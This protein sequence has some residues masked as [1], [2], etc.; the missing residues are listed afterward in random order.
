LAAMALITDGGDEDELVDDAGALVLDG[1]RGAVYLAAEQRIVVRDSGGEDL[2]RITRAQVVGALGAALYDQHVGLTRVSRMDGAAE[3]SGPRSVAAGVSAAFE[4]RYVDGLPARLQDA[5]ADASDRG[6]GDDPV[7]LVR[8]LAMLSDDLGTGLVEMALADG[9]LEED[10]SEWAVVDSLVASPPRTEF[11]L[12]QPWAT[13]DGFERVVVPAP[14]VDEGVEV[15]AEGR[16]GAATLYWTMALRV[17]AR[18]ALAVSLL[19]AGDAHVL[20]R[21]D[22]G[23]RCLAMSV[24]GPD[25]DSS[26]R[27]E[28]VLERWVE[29][30]PSDADAEIERDGRVVTLRTCEAPD[31]DP[32]LIIDPNTVVIVT[33]ARTVLMADLRAEGSSRANAVCVADEV[34]AGIPVVALTEPDP[35]PEAAILYELLLEDSHRAC[36]NV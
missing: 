3:A 12:L 30:G 4:S 32:G 23:R 36:R 31:E 14:E 7:D 34:L 20:Y 11:E 8:S 29:A 19:W 22:D 24:V 18:D 2:D 21:D 25:G 26:D 16:F 15:L 33:V 35:P 1:G 13:V 28:A 27:I 17:D 10:V 9:G 6:L 5:H